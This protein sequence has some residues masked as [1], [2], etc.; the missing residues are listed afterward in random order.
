MVEKSGSMN[1][2]LVATK[3]S[4]LMELKQVIASEDKSTYHVKFC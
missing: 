3:L 4:A 1:G 2:V